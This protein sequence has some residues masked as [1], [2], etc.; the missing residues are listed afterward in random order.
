MR[1]GSSPAT[2]RPSARALAPR[3]LRAELVQLAAQLAQERQDR[4]RLAQR[5]Q[6]LAVVPELL[7]RKLVGPLHLARADDLVGAVDRRDRPVPGYPVAVLCL[8]RLVGLD[9]LVLGHLAHEAGYL[10]A[11]ALLELFRRGIGVLDDVMQQRR[12]D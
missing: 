11:E 12:G 10:G 5:A 3:A 1:A 7:I 4:V 8:P 2:G 9:A 6:G